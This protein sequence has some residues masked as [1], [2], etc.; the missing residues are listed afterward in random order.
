MRF[1]FDAITINETF[2]FRNEPQFEAFENTLV[3][4]CS[5]ARGPAPG[6]CA[7]GVPPVLPGGGAHDLR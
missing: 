6:A 4:A 1:F 7:C 2:F 5:P 3:P